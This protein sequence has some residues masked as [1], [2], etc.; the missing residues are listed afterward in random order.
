M[1][2]KDKRE[3]KERK[4]QKAADAEQ[5]RKS[6]LDGA[7][8]ATKIAL[9]SAKDRLLQ[10][11]WTSDLIHIVMD[12][13]PPG[14]NILWTGDV[15]V[16]TAEKRRRVFNVVGAFHP[17]EGEDESDD[18]GVYPKWYGVKAEELN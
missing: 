3:K 12:A 18:V 14:D 16:G 2:K 10:D 11:G 4:E 15:F 9:L 1:G 6:M 13:N 7:H 17:A 5:A 8:Y